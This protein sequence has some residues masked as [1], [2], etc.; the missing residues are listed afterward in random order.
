MNA[1]NFYRVNEQGPELLNQ[2]G[3]TYLMMGQANGLITPLTSSGMNDPV[4]ND[5]SQPDNSQGN[6]GKVSGKVVSISGARARNSSTQSNSTKVNQ[7]ISITINPS[8]GM[9]E[10]DIADAVAQALRQQQ[11]EIDDQYNARYHD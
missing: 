5:L 2:G 7:T 1:G 10:Q 6:D 8:A 3:D 4:F 9:N 11:R